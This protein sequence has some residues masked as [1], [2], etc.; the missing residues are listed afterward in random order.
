MANLLKSP[1]FD[2]H[3]IFSPSLCGHF[4]LGT[5]SRPCLKDAVFAVNVRQ[6]NWHKIQ[7]C[8]IWHDKKH[9]IITRYCLSQLRNVDTWFDKTSYKKYSSWSLKIRIIYFY[10]G[11]CTHQTDFN[12]SGGCFGTEIIKNCTKWSNIGVH[13]LR[14]GPIK[15]EFQCASFLI[16]KNVEKW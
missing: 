16:Q 1:D 14:L 8:Q 2:E 13:G 5:F 15:A 4:A 10:R 3:L 9:R 11:T 6:N 12:L 7:K